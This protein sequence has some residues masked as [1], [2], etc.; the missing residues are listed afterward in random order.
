MR[1]SRERVIA[2]YEDGSVIPVLEWPKLPE[3][4]VAASLYRP[5]PTIVRK[6]GGG[7]GIRT[8]GRVSPSTVFKTAGFNHSPIPPF[9]IVSDF[10]E[11]Q[12]TV[13]ALKRRLRG[14]Q[15][16]LEKEK[17]ARW[18]HAFDPQVHLAR[19]RPRLGQRLRSVG[20]TGGSAGRDNG[21]HSTFAGSGMVGRRRDV[22]P[23]NPFRSFSNGGR[24][25][26]DQTE[27][28]TSDVKCPRPF[29][30]SLSYLH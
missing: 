20:S 11:F 21:S 6:Y 7:R 27:E 14:R 18:S 29:V 25:R 19:I 17:V 24:V 16:R 8:P 28:R 3:V 15:A 10:I 26:M 9:T 23:G 30:H 13:T 2:N 22:R 1:F 12:V 5:S 4:R